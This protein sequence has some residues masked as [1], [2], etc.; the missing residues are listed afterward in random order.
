MNYTNTQSKTKNTQS[1]YLSMVNT[2][3]NKNLFC[4]SEEMSQIYII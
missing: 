1:I 2:Q 3:F 4:F